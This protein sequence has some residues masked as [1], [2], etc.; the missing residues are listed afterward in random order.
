M[1]KS[2]VVP[3][4]SRCQITVRTHHE[5]HYPRP[6]IWD[7][8]Y[9]AYI[10]LDFL[11]SQVSQAIPVVPGMT[12]IRYNMKSHDNRAPLWDLIRL[13]LNAI[14]NAYLTSPQNIYHIPRPTLSTAGYLNE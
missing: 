11:F 14:I 10:I 12:P 6:T 4:F 13:C 3:G 8:I 9:S 7:L 5:A 1:R 2:E